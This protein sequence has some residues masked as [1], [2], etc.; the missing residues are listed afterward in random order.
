MKWERRNFKVKCQGEAGSTEC[1]GSSRSTLDDY[2]CF[3]V[4]KTLD[5]YTRARPRAR[6]RKSGSCVAFAG[7]WNCQL[8]S[9][10]LPGRCYG[11]ETKLLGTIPRLPPAKP[12][13]HCSSTDS[14]CVMTS[15]ACG[16]T[17]GT[18]HL[19]T[20][21]SNIKG[22]NIVFSLN[23]LSDNLH[24]TNFIQKAHFEQSPSYLAATNLQCE[25]VL[26]LCCEVKLGHA[27]HRWM[28]GSDWLALRNDTRERNITA[29]VP[30][31]QVIKNQSAQIIK[32]LLTH[33]IPALS[34]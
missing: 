1:W 19:L 7:C 30:L 5:Q 12:T 6:C 27:F 24:A 33:K 22:E 13:I 8:Q 15:P 2:F 28:L 25:L 14:T 9:F 23:S 26:A 34:F 4:W 18:K 31:T 11:I 17:S 32:H 20:N 29:F 21:I 3:I 16:G 10:A